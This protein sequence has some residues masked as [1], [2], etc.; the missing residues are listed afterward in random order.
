LHSTLCANGPLFRCPV[1]AAAPDPVEP[2]LASTVDQIV[3]PFQ[4][5]LQESGYLFESYPYPPRRRL[6]S[7][8]LIDTSQHDREALQ[9]RHAR[10]GPNVG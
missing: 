9:G 5:G 6:P 10:G 7:H 2:D 3:G 8:L 4:F 1:L